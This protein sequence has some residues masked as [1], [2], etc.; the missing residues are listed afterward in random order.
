MCTDDVDTSQAS[1][2]FGYPANSSGVPSK[3]LCEPDYSGSWVTRIDA[4]LHCVMFAVLSLK[5]RQRS[6]HFLQVVNEVV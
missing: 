4:M 2:D 3:D 5:I 6:V 1:C